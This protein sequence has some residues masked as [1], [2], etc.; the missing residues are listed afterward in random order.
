VVAIEIDKIDGRR[1]RGLRTRDAIISA[2]L[3]LVAGGDV[4]PTAQRIA[5]RA[6][7]SV[8]SVY[9][10]FADVEGLYAD[11][12]DRTY[13]WVRESAK[14]VEASLP[15]AGRVDAF[16]DDR[17]GALEALLP[18]HRA[19]RLMEPNSDRVQGYRLAM[20]KWEKD[21]VAEV[22]A[23]ELRAMDSPRRSAVLAGVDV[24]AS[25]DSWDHLRRNG[26]S[27]RAARQVVRTG[28][29]CLLGVTG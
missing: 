29:L 25:A 11:A 15:V 3:D 26:Q 10:H 12:A 21:R 8:R 1:A 22:F 13:E 9:Q 20:E 24:L 19:V 17:T 27:A 14:E 5:D 23:P 6:G 16:V 4:A 7:V 28:I 18:F 2:L